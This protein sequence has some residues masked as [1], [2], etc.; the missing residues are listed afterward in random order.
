MGDYVASFEEIRLTDAGRAGG[1]GA[2]L[3]EMVGAD[4]P[5]PPGFVILRSTYESAVVEGPH[6]AEIDALHA[7]ALHSAAADDD[8][9][10]TRLD[11][12]C[13]RMRELV[14]DTPIDHAIQ[15]A[16]VGAYHQL[17]E[18]VR[19]AVRSSAVGEDSADAS[20]AG[21]NLSRTNV[22]GD[23]QLLDALR[24]CWASLFTPRVLTYRARRGMDRRPEMAV[25]V[26]QMVT[27][28][29]AGVAFTADPTTGRRDR[30]VI[31]AARGQ[32]EVVVSGAVEP[33]TYIFTADGPTLI[34]SRRGAQSF[35]IMA[36]EDGDRRVDLP[37]DVAHRP[38]LSTA[39]ATAV[40]RLAL[41]V[42][43][44]YGRPQ[45]VE[46]AFDEHRLWLVQSRPITT[47]PDESPTPVPEA[48]A[49]AV[50]LQGLPAAPGRA[51]G[52]VRILRAPAEGST[53][54]DGEILVAPMTNPDWLPTISRAAALV[55]D[56]GGR[57]CHAAIVARE[58]GIPCVV[59]ARTATSTLHDGQRVVVDARAGRILAD[60]SPEQTGTGATTAAPAVAPIPASEATGTKI[61]VNLALPEIAERVA[62]SDVDGVGLLRA[63]T[64]L[65]RALSGRHPRAVIAAGD[66]NA[67]VTDLA[68]SL[69]RIAV[70]F[71][72]RPVVYRATDLRSNEFRTLTGGAG[73][74]PTERNPMIG[75]RGCY[76][77]VHEPDVFRLEL[78]ALARVR[79]Y[80]PNLHLMIPFV[81][82]RWELAACLELVDASPLGRDRTLRRW[83]MAEV[84]S[85][86]HWLPEYVR[87]GIDG[88]SIG[89]NDLT[90]L[91]LGVDRDSE[92]CAELFDE[93]DP[94]VLDAIERI[95]TSARE[96]G[97][98]SSL[99]GQAP[100][101]RP[102][103]AE[104]LVAAGITSI[105][106]TPDAVSRTR[107][108]VAAAERRLLLDGCLRRADTP[109]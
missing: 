64:L 1:K 37:E 109:R 74:E 53:L 90:Q 103:F 92:E 73:F 107:R 44:H 39:E 11:Q 6:G 3:G 75:Y 62:D 34:E 25:V 26:Q 4:L 95:V 86:V 67:F 57:T 16:I 81:R 60:S 68:E 12:H 31:D 76:R 84:P 50:V 97:I 94:A 2:N 51:R 8:A 79:D 46:W 15:D 19:V 32:G 33:D 65:T 45:D 108:A 100:S 99:C 29:C 56:S 14:H 22:Q 35:A 38:V 66:E 91:V 87:L 24:Q 55:T 104:Q 20:F 49:G 27:V 82:T 7:A 96:L 72:P 17:G 78:A 40:A 89:S 10:R 21:M 85:V 18:R 42:Q 48:A 93:S 77:Y 41:E 28:R 9:E 5:V 13:A 105:S 106:V 71:A 59:G 43:R 47:L 23:E 102:E 98:T 70:A 101:A 63:E 61:Y 69:Q 52:K 58:L 36:G 54:R 80:T 88:V 30:I 83:I